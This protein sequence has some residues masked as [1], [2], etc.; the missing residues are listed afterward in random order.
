MQKT[1]IEAFKCNWL[2]NIISV[3][4]IGNRIHIV[5]NKRLV[6]I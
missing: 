2:E 1:I 3:S 4:M 5:T 6:I